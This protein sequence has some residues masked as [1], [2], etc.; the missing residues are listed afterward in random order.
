ME[1]IF[2]GHVDS[3]EFKHLVHEEVGDYVSKDQMFLEDA[4]PFTDEEIIDAIRG[5]KVQL[6]HL[7]DVADR[8]RSFISRGGNNGV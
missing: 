1:K 3:E 7:K 2:F 6:A 8:L 4:E 5:M